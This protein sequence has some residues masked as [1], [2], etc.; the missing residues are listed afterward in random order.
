[1]IAMSRDTFCLLQEQLESEV[2]GANG[3]SPGSSPSMTA[4][5]SSSQ[6]EACA[7]NQTCWEGYTDKPQLYIL[8]VPMMLALGVR[9]F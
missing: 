1:M 6:A 5:S 2:A 3:T 8:S 7:D 9:H 4:S